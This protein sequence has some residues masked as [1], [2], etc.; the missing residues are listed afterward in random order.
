VS[1]WDVANVT[2]LGHMFS[3]CGSFNSDVSS[4]GTSNATF[5]SRMFRGCRSFD[6]DV[7]ASWDVSDATSLF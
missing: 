3:G 5:L 4:W 2:L 7:V 1:S 6:R